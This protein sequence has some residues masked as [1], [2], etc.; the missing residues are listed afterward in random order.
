VR[1][2][3]KAFSDVTIR[4]EPVLQLTQSYLDIKLARY[5]AAKEM[6][7][8][9]E[10][11]IESAGARAQRDLTIVSALRRVYIDDLAEGDWGA[12]IETQVDD[13]AASDHL[14]RGTLL[15][16]VAV[17]ALAVGDIDKTESAGRRA[18]QEMRAAGSVLGT[19][20]CFLHLAQSQLLRGR[21]REAESLFR[22]ALIM[23]EDNF[24]ADSGL[25]S[26]SGSFLS[27]CL[28]LRNDLAGSTALLDS[29]LEAVETSD[30]WLDVFTTAYE[31]AVRR[32]FRTSGVDEAMEVIS[33]ASH[34]ARGRKL[35]RLAA[36]AAAWRVKYLAMS[37]HIKEA[38]S[39]AKAGGVIAAAELRGRPNFSWRAR[40]AA[41]EAIAHLW[42]TT[43]ASA[44]ALT[45]LDSARQEFRNARLL[46][47]A[48]CLD[49]LSVLALKAR[50]SESEAVHRLESLLEFIVAEGTMR[51]VLDLGTPI[52]SLLHIAQRRNRE[53]VA[54]GA[55]RDVIAQLLADLQREHPRDQGGF[56]SR[57]LEVLRELCN[58][59]SNKAIG[60]LLD[61]SENTVKFHL[62]RVFKKLDVESRTAAISAAL[63]R[64][65]VESTDARKK[66]DRHRLG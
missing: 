28:Y 58:G 46:L 65:L 39:E 64:G 9:T 18:I 52:E 44:Q 35:E 10:T 49:S 32:A 53:M 27:Y 25:K 13:L 6:L 41:T 61:L 24:G 30:G 8:L 48:Y 54:S 63:Q 22:E 19:N 33:R 40:Y 14:G 12:V 1:T 56:S 11:L 57:E 16:A 21:L 50:G 55:Q 5:D 3:L 20:Y 17:S 43:G 51:V 15:A 66:P 60:Q 38:R 31:I 42:I 59:R 47:P 62:K 29:S 7:A 34:T 36:L 37:G 2:L 23:A 26:L 45:L 4:S